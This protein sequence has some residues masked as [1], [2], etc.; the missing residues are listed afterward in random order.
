MVVALLWATQLPAG[1][2][3]GDTVLMNAWYESMS[4]YMDQSPEKALHFVHAGLHHA[5]KHGNTLWQGYFL[6]AGGIVHDIANHMD[7]GMA[8]YEKTLVLARA[9]KDTVL[10]ANA[11]GN[12]GAAYH[13][14]GYLQPALNYHLQA[15]RLR[16][17]MSNRY[18]L[19]K[20]YNNIGLL[21]R[22]L[23]DYTHAI[24]YFNR[25]IGIKENVADTL[26]LTTT[27]LNLSS[28]YIYRKYYDSALYYGRKSLDLAEFTG[29]FSKIA[30]A[31]A[32]IGLA[33]L[34][35]NKPE[36]ALPYLINA[37]ALAEDGNFDEEYFA[38]YKGLGEYYDKMNNLNKSYYWYHVGWQKALALQRRE[39]TV[40]F[41][42]L[43]AALE[44][45]RGNSAEAY[46]LQVAADRTNDSLLNEA[47]IR[48]LNEM[49]IVYETEL[50][51][52]R[53]QQLTNE[54][55]VT[56]LNLLQKNRE[57]NALLAGLLLVLTVASVVAWS[58]HSHKK[59][60]TQLEKQQEIIQ[61]QLQEKEVLMREI[62][63]RVKNN[64]QIISGLLHLQSRHIDDPNALKA[65]R[66]GRNRVKSIALI[67]QQLYQQE[68]LTEIKLKEYLQELMHSIHQSF[69]DDNKKIVQKLTCPEIPMD[70]EIAVPLGLIINECVTNAYK[71]AFTQAASGTMEVSIAT[72][73]TSMQLIIQDDGKGLPEGFEWKHQ[74]SFG[75]KMIGNLVNKLKANFSI[76]KREGT[77]IEIYIPNYTSIT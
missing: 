73:H 9:V 3:K 77:R 71:H 34:G 20:S 21:Y 15:A 51:E 50:K 72:D 6:Q 54:A 29:N 33:W 10:E 30:V 70:V 40:A 24:D 65:V 2:Q 35:K 22:L 66:E 45:K 16:E 38:I 12:I 47:T 56:Q 11:L 61:T 63:H 62:H 48:Q 23:K 17:N 67:H 49:N 1:G 55:L 42:R 39:F 25:S 41:E 7:S 69:K 60:N 46:L 5:Q 14:R 68:N 13:A 58:W 36:M 28:C 64:L 31:K 18:Y 44:Y 32:N 57:R 4:S 26:G 75:I 74:K 37:A 43:L 52:A 59:K 53:I 19:A 76:Y 27:L 8:Y